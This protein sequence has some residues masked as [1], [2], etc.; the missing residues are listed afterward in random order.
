MNRDEKIREI[1]EKVA[2]NGC[3]GT[4]KNINQ[5]VIVQALSQLNALIDEQ[6]KEARA[7]QEMETFCAIKKKE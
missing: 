6:I 5:R 7:H 3:K 1:L 2:K 4:S